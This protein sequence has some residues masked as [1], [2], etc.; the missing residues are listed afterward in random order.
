MGHSQ[1]AR[2][3]VRS[4]SHP[5]SDISLQIMA[6]VCADNDPEDHEA[7]PLFDLS[8]MLWTNG[9]EYPP[10]DSDV[11]R[12]FFRFQLLRRPS[13]LAGPHSDIYIYW[14]YCTA[15]LTNWLGFK[16]AD[17]GG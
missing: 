4:S 6:S 14:T 17:T 3:M 10:P 12:L 1:R 7:I 16:P 2:N 5:H 13:V 8:R 15:T 11:L 9:S